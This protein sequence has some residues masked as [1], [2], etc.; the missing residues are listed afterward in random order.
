[1]VAPVDI[2]NIAL[3]RIGQPLLTSLED[4]D[5]KAAKYA[6]LFYPSSR[7]QMLRAFPWRRIKKRIAVAADPAAPVWGYDKRYALPSDLLRLLEV[8]ANDKVIRNSEW[9][10]EG[11]WL[12][13]NFDG[14]LYLRY[15]YASTDPNE[16]DVLMHSV[17]A[18]HLAVELAEP[19]TQDDSKKRL[20]VQM[21]QL[22]MADARH[23][24]A[25]EGNPVK[26]N[27]PDSWESVRY[28]G[29]DPTERGISEP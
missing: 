20:A 3:G 19:L 11:N 16:W 9:E 14:P 12:L 13:T 18:A 23:A 29:G 27:T 28:G 17:I 8:A 10:L 26:L 4:D 1:M 24:N 5:G 22:V 25:Q 7:D 2:V 15:L 6:R 21:F